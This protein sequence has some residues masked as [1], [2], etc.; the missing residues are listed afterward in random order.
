MSIHNINNTAA[1]TQSN[2]LLKQ[3]LKKVIQNIMWSH[4]IK[5]KVTFR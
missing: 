1:H 5:T 2:V 4:T 3:N